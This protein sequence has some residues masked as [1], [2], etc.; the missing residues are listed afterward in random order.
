MKYK[1]NY[2]DQRTERL[3]D[4]A[5]E[6]LG[7]APPCL[8][9]FIRGISASTT[10]ETRLGY[11]YDLQIFFRYLSENKFFKDVKSITIDDM[12]NV[13]SDDIESFLDY[14]TI[15]K[16]NGEYV[17]N[18]D[19]AKGRK[20]SSIKKMF[21]FFTKRRKLLNN[22]AD[23]VEPPK[24]REKNIIM[25]TDEE[26]IKIISNAE[27][28]A[29]LSKKALE[30]HNRF[31]NRDVAI[32]YL[33]LGT[34][35]RIS[36]LVGIDSHDVDFSQNSVKIT[37][38]GGA[39][40]VVYFGEKVKER[41]EIYLTERKNLPANDDALFLSRRNGRIADRSVQYLVKKYSRSVGEKIS[42]HKFRSTY[43]TKL[44]RESRDIYLVAEALGH[45]DVNTTKKH[46]AKLD[47][48][49]RKEAPSFVK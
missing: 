22:P 26:V 47:D 2:S 45:K 15:Y 41:L 4:R 16:S 36:E 10:A 43:G 40:S 19:E 12:A 5:I 29:C 49:R 48:E 14:V 1:K 44:Y 38:K 20:F 28:G 11:I 9:D 21:K 3:R 32:I 30:Y 18:G 27:T 23:I 6:L 33:L 35:I 34:G 24:I 8:S 46:Y 17:K 7:T 25:L 42:P 37:R 31:K 39:E 13:D